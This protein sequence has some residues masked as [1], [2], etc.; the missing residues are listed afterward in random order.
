MSVGA[1]VKNSEG[2]IAV[3]H[4]KNIKNVADVYHLMR[5]TVRP[6]ESLESALA[7][8]LK[9]EFG[10]EAN[11]KA[12]LGSYVGSFV[13]WGGAKIQ[14]TTLY[15]L[16]DLVSFNE[17]ERVKR[18]IDIWEGQESV[19]EWHDIEFLIPQ[20]K[21]QAEAL[22]QSDMDESSVLERL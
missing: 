3:H 15:F 8:G 14:K 21:E 7:R 5:Q 11:I 6:H 16:C 9:I 18:D 4:Y 17:A 2:K 13:N 10:M 12:F 1:V 20:M 19:I 22:N